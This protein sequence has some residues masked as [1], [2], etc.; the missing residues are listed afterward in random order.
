MNSQCFGIL[1]DSM[2]RI[3]LMVIRSI[4]QLPY[5][6]VLIFRY[7]NVEKYEEQKRYTF[8]HRLTT[9]VNRRG[10]VTVNC[11]GLENLPKDNGYILYPNH[12]GLFDALIILETHEHPFATV[13]KKEVENI[14][15]LKQIFNILQSKFI[16]REDVRQSMKIMI[17]VTKEVKEGRNYLIFP[18]GTR[19]K[20]QNQIQEFKGGSFKSAMNAK[21]PIVPV[22]IIDSY[23][24]FDTNSIK[25]LTVQ[26]HYLKPLYYED[27]K[28]MKSGEIATIVSGMIRETI[29]EYEPKIS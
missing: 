15:F 29:A 6:L 28:D 7:T 26:I 4:F 17:E 3:I 19:S 5:W 12:Q 14:F 16:D 24:A 21:C 23:K 11:F 27:Y 22:A 10:R 18:E 8:L 13:S 1:E 25:K 2:K 20:N 9:I